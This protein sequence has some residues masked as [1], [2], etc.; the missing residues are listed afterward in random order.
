[1]GSTSITSWVDVQSGYTKSIFYPAG[2]GG[3][4]G[5]DD[6]IIG[7]Q[8]GWTG[9]AP[10]VLRDSRPYTDF[11]FVN[12][13]GAVETCSAQMLESMSIDVDTKQYSRVERP[14]F[15][16]T[17]SVMAIPSGGRRSWGMSSGY[18]VREWAEWWTTEFLMARQWWMLYKGAYIPVIVEPAKKSTGIYDRAKQQFPSV[19]FTVT[20]ALEG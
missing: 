16:P 9:H 11:L 20:L 18:Q 7:R 19:E 17:R 10:T 6:D 8:Q 15:K 4:Q 13:R 1:M 3:D 12:R 5:E 14:A 2:F